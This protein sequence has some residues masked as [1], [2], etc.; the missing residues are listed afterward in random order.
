M[1]VGR[2]RYPTRT[3]W[4]Y[5]HMARLLADLTVEL[6]KLATDGGLVLDVYCGARPYEDLLAEGVKCIGLDV[7]EKWGMADVISSEFLPFTDASFDGVMCT[8]AFGYVADPVAAVGEFARVLRPG[9]RVLITM[10]FVYEYDR[11]K[12]EHRFTGPELVELFKGWDEVTLVE[13]GGRGVTWARVTNSVIT[14]AFDRLV[15]RY[16]PARLLSPL[17]TAAFVFVTAVG[18]TIETLDQRHRRSQ[19]TLPANLMVTARRSPAT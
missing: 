6:P 16:R 5:L 4:D 14:S 12:L 7:T 13:Q 11:M 1:D 8:Q 9:G 10:D 3:Q 15:A 17:M 18:R 19:S 2:R